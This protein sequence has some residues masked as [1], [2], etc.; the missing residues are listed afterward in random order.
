MGRKKGKTRRNCVSQ[1]KFALLRPPLRAPNLPA[2]RTAK[3]VPENHVV[4]A[5]FAPQK[6]RRTYTRNL[7]EA[8]PLWFK[9]AEIP[10]QEMWQDDQHWLPEML[11]GKN[12]S[13]KFTFDDETM[14]DKE[15]RIIG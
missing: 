7:L 8:E 6:L 10:Y 5:K 13:A 1:H 12:F 3:T 15:V 14:L 4:N 11:A 9:A 2:V